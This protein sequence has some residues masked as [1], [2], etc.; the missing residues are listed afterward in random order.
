MLLWLGFAV[1]ELVFWCAGWVFGVSVVGRIVVM[2]ASLG[3]N[4]KGVTTRYYR[5]SVNSCG[6][7]SPSGIGG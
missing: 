1:G 4:G 3:V 6:G 7:T 5:K 2:E